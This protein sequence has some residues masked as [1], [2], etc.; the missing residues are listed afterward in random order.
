MCSVVRLLWQRRLAD[1]FGCAYNIDY[2]MKQAIAE[3]IV[4]STMPVL[5][6]QPG[7]RQI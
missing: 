6:R 1:S 2:E 4:Y 3:S 5:N 7:G